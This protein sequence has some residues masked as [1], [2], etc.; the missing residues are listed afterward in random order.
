MK[1]LRWVGILALLLVSTADATAAL[2]PSFRLEFCSWEATH[3][4]VVTE[5]DK[6][7]GKV[8]VVESWKGDLKKGDKLTVPDLAAFAPEKERGVS[9]GLFARDDTKDL[10]AAVSGSRMILFLRKQVEAEK[11]KP[12]KTNWLP[13]ADKWGGMK[14]STAW[15]EGD[16]VFAFGQE[17]NP[18]PQ[19]LLSWGMDEKKLKKTVDAVVKDQTVLT[20]AIR[21]GDADKLTTAVLELVRSESASASEP[22]FVPNAVV[23]ELADT[24]AKGLPALRAILKDHKLLK[25][26][27]TAVR[28]IAKAGGADAGPE[29]VKVLE[30]ELA[31]WKKVGPDLPGDWWS[32]A[33]GKVEWEEVTRLRDHYM[34]A[35][36]A[37]IELGKL[38][39]A[40]GREVVTEFAEYHRSLPQ[41]A[42]IKQLGEACDTTLKAMPRR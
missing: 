34:V 25:Y 1:A 36:A 16:K 20:E 4:V 18:G 21:K 37:V 5:G 12:T 8:E 11:D 10:P 28:S 41:L 2:M 31:F 30:Q 38:R 15:I 39:H 7:D 19:E 13:A 42:A 32:G 26:H 14:V 24:G 27:D 23:W 35:Y 9:K 6:I 22:T 3:I 33:R 29:L 17:M 40:G